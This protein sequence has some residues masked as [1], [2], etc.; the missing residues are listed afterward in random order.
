MNDGNV[1]R[2]PP[3]VHKHYGSYK[4]NQ[5]TLPDEETIDVSRITHESDDE[6]KDEY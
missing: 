3:M 6:I 4:N 1:L 2:L 5:S